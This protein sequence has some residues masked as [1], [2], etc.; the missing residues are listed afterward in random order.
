[1]RVWSGI[2]L[3]AAAVLSLGWSE[4]LHA[5]PGCSEDAAPL[6]APVAALAVLGAVPVDRPSLYRLAANT[7]VW[8]LLFPD[9]ETQGRALNRVAAL[10]EARGARHDRILSPAA[11]AK[12]IARSGR[13]G[14]SFVYGHDYRAADVARFFALAQRAAT[15]LTTDEAA[16][17]CRLRQAGF[18]L[19]PVPNPAALIAVAAGPARLAALRHEVS[20]GE[21]FTNPRYR[22]YCIG[23]WNR[24]SR[25]QR[26]IFREQ[27]AQLGYDPAND[28]LIINEMQAFLWEETSG[29][30][31]DLRLRRLGSSQAALRRDFLTGIDQAVGAITSLFAD[32][33][34]RQVYAYEPPGTRTLEKQTSPRP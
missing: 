17:G 19:G 7:A 15:P 30:V 28:D 25:E 20:H 11:L 21:F 4:P 14:A 3:A 34:E 16:V 26:A 8:V 24:L 13:T 22:A 32:P 18:P 29:A 23:F 9:A 10:V 6:A 1:M 27:L 2:A 31:I 5:A 12:L 33:L